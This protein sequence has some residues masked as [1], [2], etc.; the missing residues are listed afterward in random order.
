MHI[1]IWIVVGIVAG[2]LT[3]LVMKGKSY[4]IVGDL[5]IGLLGG[6]VGGFIFGLLG[7]SPTSWVGQIL[8]S[9]VGGI[10]LVAAVRVLRK[11]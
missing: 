10:V 8:V 3:G 7:L 9:L 2:W 5:I 4:G 6:V 11:A 1:L